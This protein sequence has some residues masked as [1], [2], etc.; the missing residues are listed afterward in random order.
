MRDS[1]ARDVLPVL[2]QVLLFRDQLRSGRP[3]DLDSVQAHLRGQLN[4]LQAERL[5]PENLGVRY[6]VISWVDEINCMGCG[7]L[8][9]QREWSNLTLEFEQYGTRDRAWRF[10]EQARQASRRADPDALE[11]FYLCMLLGFRGDLR[12]ELGPL[13]D[14]RDAVEKQIGLKQPADCPALPHSLEEPAGDVPD[15]TAKKRL[16]WV[17]LSWAVVLSLLIVLLGFVSVRQAFSG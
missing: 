9:W 16:R 17:L 10:W 3:L 12:G 14:W 5:D 2:R 15:L 8:N 7:D 6:T 11:V 1:L 4:S 13:A